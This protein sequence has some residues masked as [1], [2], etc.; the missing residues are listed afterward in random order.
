M[1]ARDYV[2]TLQSRVSELEE[3][4]RML[5]QLQ[6]RRNNGGDVSPNKI[7]VD[8]R[9]NREEIRKHHRNFT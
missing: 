4:N 1:R 7:E 2:S 8:I 6:H 5:V 3:K 9:N